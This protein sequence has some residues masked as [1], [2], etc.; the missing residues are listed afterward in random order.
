M[1][2]ILLK[3]ATA[4]RSNAK[5]T[6]SN[7]AGHECPGQPVVPLRLPCLMLRNRPPD[8]KT[9]YV[10]TR[11]GALLICVCNDRSLLMTRAEGR[12]GVDTLSTPSL[13]GRA[14]KKPLDIGRSDLHGR[15]ASSSTSLTA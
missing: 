9:C 5:R 14:S 13:W 7:A 15:L 11:S 10:K 2:G 12:L 4:A 8:L 6:T 3:N 1:L